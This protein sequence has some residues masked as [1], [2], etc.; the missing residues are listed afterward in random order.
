MEVTQDPDTEST[1]QSDSGN[2]LVEEIASALDS[3]SEHEAPSPSQENLLTNN[4]N[5]EVI[6][7]NPEASQSQCSADDSDVGSWEDIGEEDVIGDDAQIEEAC[8]EM[9][10]EDEPCNCPSCYAPSKHF[11]ERVKRRQTH[12]GEPLPENVTQYTSKS[13]AQVYIVGT[14]HF[15]EASQN[16]VSK[17]IEVLNP[18]VVMVELCQSRMGVLKYD[19]ES[20]LKEAQD[21]S[22]AKLRMA[23]QESGVLSGVMQLLLLS[24][25]AHVT[26]QLGMAPG[27]EFRRA[28]K[29][30]KKVPGCC[31]IL[32]DRPI[33]VTL[34]RAMGSLSMW[35]KT[36]LAWHLIFSRDD[37]SKE[38]VEKYKQKDMIAEMLAEMTGDY[39]ELSRVFV[40]ERDKYMAALLQQCIYMIEDERRRQPHCTLD[41]P[42][43]GET[44]GDTAPEDFPEGDI[45]GKESSRKDEGSIA[46][47]R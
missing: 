7:S 17:T 25:S 19:E 26:K 1:A 27:G 33:Q 11:T 38:D 29:E 4:K 8:G 36:K 34:G 14:A 41:P 6:E 35:Q 22:L 3:N 10:R 24:M 31:L 23:I 20:L 30:A 12:L 16:D 32:G 21:V 46:E 44:Q 43:E 5:E 45:Q 9:E 2:S 13:G 42:K 15:S 28:A 37:I 40:D 39:P 47:G 18:D